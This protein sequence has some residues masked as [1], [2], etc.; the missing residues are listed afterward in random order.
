MDIADLQHLAGIRNKYTGYSEY[1]IDEN[2]S[3]TADKL[4]KKEKEMKLKPGDADWFK[5]WFSQPYMTGP[6]QFRGRKR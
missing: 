6:V 1:K 5:L 2:P 4:K 3:I